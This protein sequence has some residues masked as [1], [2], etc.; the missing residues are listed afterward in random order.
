MR[1]V[2]EI[3]AKIEATNKEIN[4]L[5]DELDKWPQPD[6]RLIESM[7]KD[8]QSRRDVLRKQLGEAMLDDD[9]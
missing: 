3:K 5:W 2:E 8:Q 1:A 6:R 4:R 9:E 7:I